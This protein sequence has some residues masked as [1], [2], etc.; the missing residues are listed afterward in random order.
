LVSALVQSLDC[1]VTVKVRAGWQPGEITAPEIAKI[2]VEAGA[3]MVTVHGRTK[4]GWYQERVDKGVIK[5]VREALPSEI[6]VIGNGDVVDLPSALAMFEE[7]GCNGVMI[8]RGAVG[9]PW[10]FRRIV[11]YQ[12]TG[13]ILPEPTFAEVRELYREHMASVQEMWGEKQGYL[14]VRL[15]S[16]YYFGRFPIPNIRARL[17]ATKTCQ[18]LFRVIDEIEREVYDKALRCEPFATSSSAMN[19]A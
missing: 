14:Q 7:T 2:C 10:L 3:K 9:N 16:F 13:E 4:M 12:K 6:P 5:S 19:E 17:G 15:Y 1:P 18:Q 11:H 8:G